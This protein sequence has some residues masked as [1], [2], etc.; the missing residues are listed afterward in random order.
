MITRLTTLPAH[1]PISA[2]HPIFA[3]DQVAIVVE[4]ERFF[5]LV[6]RVDLLNFLLRSNR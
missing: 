1:A 4:G 2:L 6:T 5:G 3:A